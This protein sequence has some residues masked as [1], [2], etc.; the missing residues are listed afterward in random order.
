[1]TADLVRDYV[2]EPWTSGPT[3]L[4]PTSRQADFIIHGNVNPY[5]QPGR[6]VVPDLV[7]YL[8]MPLSK[9]SHT[10]SDAVPRDEALDPAIEIPSA[11]TWHHDITRY[12][13]TEGTIAS[14]IAFYRT[15]WRNAGCMI[16][17]RAGKVKPYDWITS[18]GGAKASMLSLNRIGKVIGAVQWRKRSGA[19]AKTSSVPGT[20]SVRPMQFAG[21]ANGRLVPV[22]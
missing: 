8:Y 13:N 15:G 22:T 20:E 12:A 19:G 14:K 10:D 18:S 9:P 16:L 21:F 4:W 6:V 1:M 3:R 7:L 17:I 2:A 5:R 11:T